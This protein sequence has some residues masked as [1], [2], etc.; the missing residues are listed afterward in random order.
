MVD[1]ETSVTMV[2]KISSKSPSRQGARTE[3]LVPNRGFWWRRRSGSLSEKNAE[4]PLFSGQRVYV[5][6]RRGRGD[7]RGGLTTGG[8]GQGWAAPLVV[9]PGRC[10]PSSLLLAPWV[11]WQNRIFAVF[12]RIFSESR[13]SAQKR[14]T[15]AILLKTTLVR[16]SC[17][18]NTQIRG[19]T[20]AKM[21][22]KV[23]TFWTYHTPQEAMN[24]NQTFGGCDRIL[25]VNMDLQRRAVTL[26]WDR[27]FNLNGLLD[28]R[29]DVNL[30]SAQ[31]LYNICSWIYLLI[32]LK[33]FLSF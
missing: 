8:R 2:M 21:F 26:P 30:L 6:G 12:S 7:G 25:P 13:I 3:F 4:P 14:D 22:W 15:R 1:G 20:I 32:S 29:S 17:I 11:F 28:S 33:W 5:G 10:P 19:N 24:S 9:S 23:D 27:F 31:G 16:V 18:Q